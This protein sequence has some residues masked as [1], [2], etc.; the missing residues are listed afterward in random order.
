[1][2][3]VSLQSKKADLRWS[4]GFVFGFMVVELVLAT[5]LG[6][7]CNSQKID[8]DHTANREALA[9]I[10]NY[11]VDEDHFVAAFKRYYYRAGQALAPDIRTKKA[12]LNEEFEPYVVAQYAIDQ[13]WDRDAE[14]A[15]YKNMIK[16]KVYAE[17][18]LNRMIL[19]TVRVR[20]AEIREL[21]LKFNTTL[22]ASHLFAR[23]KATI[24]S[25]YQLLGQGVSFDKLAHENFQNRY[26]AQNGG[27]IGYFTVDEMDLAFE[28]AAYDMKVGEISRPVKTNQGY[29][30][31]RLT[32]RVSQPIITEQQFALK[33]DQLEVISR[34]RQREM[35]TR[36]HLKHT[37]ASLNID[38]AA[39][40]QLWNEVR[41]QRTAF[42]SDNYEKAGLSVSIG[43]LKEVELARK[44]DF[45]FTGRDFL[46]EGW[47]T[48]VP[49]RSRI[50]RDFEF[51]NFVKGLMYRSYV[52]DK[53]KKSGL[54]ES[55]S[56]QGSIDET[57]T[58]YLNNRVLDT[59]R[60]SV[61]IT[62]EEL[63]DEYEKNKS[64]YASSLELNMAQIVVADEQQG[65]RVAQRLR[66]GA[67]FQDV[68]KKYTLDGESL[69]TGGELGFRP[70]E[71]FQE[72]APKVRTAK[73][74]EIMGPFAYKMKRYVVYKCLGR[75]EPRTLSF[76]EALPQ[77]RQVFV[78]SK[79]RRDKEALIEATKKRH[80]AQVDLDQLQ[81]L[82]IKL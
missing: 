10:G 39:I 54:A 6:A 74:G 22:R 68:L 45:T 59:L 40:Q 12:I 33:K 29:S 79:V 27:D 14:S 13:G 2:H 19:D 82:T 73:P 32:D 77:V 58:N 30:I 52:I 5:L 56:V 15:R 17:E 37:V 62:P 72:L 26:L 18:Y 50:N 57:F 46:R 67:N 61:E 53:F 71:R 20:E 66:Q 25:L 48:P 3:S 44:G 35:A 28:N 65:N 42:L 78:R 43:D 51:A 55:H 75:R 23:D 36:L 16:R 7:G 81:K 47:Y 11:Q 60:S 9:S 41:N 64:Q 76:E 69:M 4:R 38:E 49:S 34:K 8:D 1:M 24:D 63:R 21:F 70:V 80:D 31:I